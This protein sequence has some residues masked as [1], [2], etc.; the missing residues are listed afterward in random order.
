MT[1]RPNRR[2]RRYRVRALPAPLPRRDLRPNTPVFTGY[3]GEPGTPYRLRPRETR[4]SRV[5]RRKRKV[6]RGIVVRF[7]QESFVPQ[8]RGRRGEPEPGL[9]YW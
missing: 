2:G 9:G 3:L 4:R 8:G 5:K 1:A 6:W 7:V